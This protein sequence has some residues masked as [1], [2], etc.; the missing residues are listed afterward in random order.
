MPDFP[1]VVRAPPEKVWRAL[2]D[3]AERARVG[4]FLIEA[5]M[6]GGRIGAVDSVAFYR[7]AKTSWR[8]RILESEAPS[9]LLVEERD[10]AD[11]TRATMVWRIT[12]IRMGSLIVLEVQGKGMGDAARVRLL[13]KAR[14]RRL[15]EAVK[16]A[17]EGAP[18]VRF[19]PPPKRT[20][21]L[22]G[23][24][25]KVEPAPAEPSR[26]TVQP[27]AEPHPAPQAEPVR[28]PEAPKTMAAPAHKKPAKRRAK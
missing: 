28:T 20:F 5:S 16:L 8:E 15:V 22:P 18:V 14:Y 12:P 27:P 7:T 10:A 23:R 11:R 3:P 4:G 13:D 21:R 24:R 25:T 9:R 6:E 17:C 26:S 2:V 1:D 19:A